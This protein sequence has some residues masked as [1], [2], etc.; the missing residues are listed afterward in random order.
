[1]IFLAYLGIIPAALSPVPLVM[2]RLGGP[3]ELDRTERLGCM[4]VMAGGFVLML[5]GLA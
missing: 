1:M 2:E 4:A 5:A 3:L